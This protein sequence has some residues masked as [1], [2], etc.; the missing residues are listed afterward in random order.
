[1]T[2]LY[3]ALAGALTELVE[4]ALLLPLIGTERPDTGGFIGQVQH[5]FEAVARGYGWSI[6]FFWGGIAVVLL[7]A[8][9]R[10]W[11]AR[12]GPGAPGRD[13]L[14]VVVAVP[15]LFFIAFSL[16]DFQ[17]YPDAYPFLPLA[18][19]GVACAAAI[20]LTLMEERGQGMAALATAGAAA[21][22]VVVLTWAWYGNERPAAEAR[23]LVAQREDAAAADALLG[24]DR[25]FYALGDPSLLVLMQRRNPSPEIYMAAGVDAW[26]IQNKPG[27]FDGW[28]QEIAAAEPDMVVL[29]GWHGPNAARMRN[30]LRSQFDR[31]R[32]VHSGAFVTAELGGEANR[33][34]GA[35]LLR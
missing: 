19:F 35:L 33:P 20:G 5:I 10:L 31:V 7:L 22:F 11:K 30:W 32:L 24:P 8:G 26:V 16:Y 12:G 17:G 4:S 18:A 29:D 3:F 6:V 14:I 34:A 2:I 28:T 21:L 9:T 15:L 1:V 23:G 13:P 25:T 27:G